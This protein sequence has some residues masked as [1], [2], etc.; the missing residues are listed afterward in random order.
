[1]SYTEA[2][3][4][5][6]DLIEDVDVPDNTYN[7]IALALKKANDTEK[8]KHGE[9]AMYVTTRFAIR[10]PRHEQIGLVLTETSTGVILITEIRPGSICD[11]VGM[12]PG[13][14]I[15]EMNN[16]RRYTVQ[17]ICN[18]LR[19]ADGVITI[20]TWRIEYY[21]ERDEPTQLPTISQPSQEPLSAPE[22]THPLENSSRRTAFRRVRNA[23]N[24]ILV[25]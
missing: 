23:Y 24:S 14:I 11:L 7:T 5:L 19:Y 15:T 25:R 12:K 8:S 2:M 6:D 21:T 4:L 1:M 18:T 13:D 17:D 9:S 16:V 10:K 3:S 22:Q 20:G